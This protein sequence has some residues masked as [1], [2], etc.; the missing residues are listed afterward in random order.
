MTYDTPSV[1]ATEA[2][3]AMSEATHLLLTAHLRSVPSQ[4]EL[5]FAYWRPSR[6]R[7]RMTAVLSDPQL[8]QDGEHQVHGNAS[9]NGAY[10][11]R[12]LHER[13]TGAGIAF[14]HS[15]LGPG[16]QDMSHDDVVAERDRISGAV[17]PQS[18]LPL[19]GLT[20]GMDG[21]WSA[22][23]WSRSG[24]NQYERTWAPSVRVVGPTVTKSGRRRTPGVL[25][26]ARASPRRACGDRPFK[27]PSPKRAWVS[28]ALAASDR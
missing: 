4:E 11:R 10:L 26:T 28:S 1:R 24:P 13:P 23:F 25:N 18:D 22:R 9:F 7:R 17:C 19:L 8:P 21:T 20:L 6:G 15:H 5:A 16:W 14:L 2:S 27:T 3:V 12:V